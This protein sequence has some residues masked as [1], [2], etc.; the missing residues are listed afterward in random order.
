MGGEIKK[1]EGGRRSERKEE[2]EVGDGESNKIFFNLFLVELLCFI[3][4]L[5]FCRC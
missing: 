5:L 3:F 1:G 4:F 2:R